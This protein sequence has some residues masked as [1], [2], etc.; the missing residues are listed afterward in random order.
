MKFIWTFLL[1]TSALFVSTGQA[2]ATEDYARKTGLDCSFC[3]VNQQGGGELTQAG[4]EYRVKLV[5]DGIEAGAGTVKRVI[6]LVIG[7]L[8]ILAG[9]VWFGAIFYVHILLKPA[10]ASKGLPK[11]ELM[12]GWVCIIAV[13]VTGTLLTVAR[14]PS[15]D[16]FVT[17][18]FGILLSLKI[19]MYLL[20]AGSAALVTFVLGPK[21]RERLAAARKEG[22][23]YTVD[24]LR[25]FD[26]KDGRKA[27][28][29]VEGT[30]YDV[31]ESHFW[32]NGKHA[33]HLAGDDMTAA[34]KQ[35]PHGPEK[36]DKFLQAGRLI[37]A[38]EKSPVNRPKALFYVF[39]YMNLVLVF[40][41]LGVIALWRWW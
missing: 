21:M 7:Y 34:I 4:Q 20:M 32:K 14:T 41:I 10:Y 22:G 26:G 2:R 27:L 31:T 40:L 17:T 11:G 35:A 29:A 24:E 28:V 36:V 3:H 19:A 13:G 1:I 25:A 18:R 39:A 33:R 16:S 12:L 9:V 23:E 8:H 30:I 37:A 15:L 5:G 38:G 6:R